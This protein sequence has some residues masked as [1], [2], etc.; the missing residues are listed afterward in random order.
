[1]LE[2]DSEQ[3]HQNKQKSSKYEKDYNIKKSSRTQGIKEDQNKSKSENPAPAHEEL[4]GIHHI[5]GART[6]IRRLQEF[7]RLGSFNLLGTTVISS[8]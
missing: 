3:N 8:N 7:K 4:N 1:M 2:K 6:E 5:T